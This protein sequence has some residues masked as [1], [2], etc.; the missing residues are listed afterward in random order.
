MH[1][2]RG[3]ARAAESACQLAGNR[4]RLADP[5]QHQTALS[6]RT[7]QQHCDRLLE[8]RIERFSHALNRLDFDL[9]HLTRDL[10]RVRAL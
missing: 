5:A 3:R 6:P 4:A 8:T 1:E 9:Q 7:R 2:N 10:Q